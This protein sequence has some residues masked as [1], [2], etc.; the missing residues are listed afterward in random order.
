MKEKRGERGGT[1]ERGRGERGEGKGE[2]G[3]RE[4]KR[5]REEERERKKERER[6]TNLH[7]HVFQRVSLR[8]EFLLHFQLEGACL[9]FTKFG[10]LFVNK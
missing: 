7:L 4:R 10:G 8:E 6:N 1:G 9:S 3:E 2:G 5:E